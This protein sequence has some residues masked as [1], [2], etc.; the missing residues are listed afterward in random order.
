MAYEI[1]RFIKYNEAS[2]WDLVKIVGNNRQFEHWVTGFLIRDGFVSEPDGDSEYF[3]LTEEGEILLSLL[4]K[5]NLMYSIFK[6]SGQ[7]LRK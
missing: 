2:K 6:L 3:H 7:R 4:K 1:L 5:G